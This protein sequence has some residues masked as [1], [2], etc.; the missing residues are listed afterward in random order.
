MNNLQPPRNDDPPSPHGRPFFAAIL[1]CAWRWLSH[2]EAGT[3]R[4]MIRRYSTNWQ[5]ASSTEPNLGSSLCLLSKIAKIKLQANIPM[6]CIFVVGVGFRPSTSNLPSKNICSTL[7]FFWS[8]RL[9]ARLTSPSP[10]LF[11]GNKY[12]ALRM[13]W[14]SWNDDWSP[15]NRNYKLFQGNNAI[16]RNW[17]RTWLNIIYVSRCNGDRLVVVLYLWDQW[18]EPQRLLLPE[19]FFGIRKPWRNLRSPE[20]TGLLCRQRTSHK[21]WTSSGKW[22]H[23]LAW[24]STL[25]PSHRSKELVTC[26]WFAHARHSCDEIFSTIEVL[27][28]N[29]ADDHQHCR[30]SAGDMQ[31]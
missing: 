19:I 29:A 13:P 1:G 4:P 28:L 20:A 17:K 16:R 14:Y 31:R 11:S 10:T 6:A 23:A 15:K 30:H 27:T 25:K 7:A 21:M 2:G 5:P 3:W 22:G 18:R 8:G 26:R 12:S 9:M 24:T